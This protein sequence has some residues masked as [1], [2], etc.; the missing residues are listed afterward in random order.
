MQHPDLDLP[1]T[2]NL[3]K[4]GNYIRQKD[5]P[6][7]PTT[8]QFELQQNALPKDFFVGDITVGDRQH[9][10]FASKE[11]LRDLQNM[12]RWYVDGTFHVA[13][14]HLASCSQ[15]MGS[16]RKMESPNRFHCFMY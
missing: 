1:H 7:H 13:N 3:A 9:I 11:Q 8:L 14:F 6:L 15:S 5:R 4:A 10:L 16:S 2:D 12:R